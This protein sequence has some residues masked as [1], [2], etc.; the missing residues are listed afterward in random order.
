[1]TLS[2]Y[3][4]VCFTS[5]DVCLWFTFEHN[6]A[7]NYSYAESD[8]CIHNESGDSLIPESIV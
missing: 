2:S 7:S 1:M 5:A 3:V 4:S 6:Y 8:P